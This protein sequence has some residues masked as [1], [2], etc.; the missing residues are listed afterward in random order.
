LYRKTPEAVL[1]GLKSFWEGIDV[2][3]DKLSLVII[4]KL[5][6][7]G[8]ND[9][10]VNA[11]REAAGDAWFAHVDI[12]D[13]IFDLRQGLGRLIRTVTDTGVAAIL[14]SRVLTKPYGKTV[15]RSTGFTRAH[16]KLSQVVPVLEAQAR[17]RDK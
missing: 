3:G 14:D 8:R 10:V 13:M 1:F 7:P 11:R 4:T 9:A 16:T 5:P 6:F 12:P 15:L 17:A 2:T